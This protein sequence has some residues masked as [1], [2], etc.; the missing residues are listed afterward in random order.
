MKSGFSIP[1]TLPAP[2]HFG[3]QLRHF[4]KRPGEG[5]TRL[6]L[7]L[8]LS[9]TIKVVICRHSLAIFPFFLFYQDYYHIHYIRPC[10]SCNNMATDLLKKFKR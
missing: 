6:L 3:T 2:T 10:V 4:K 7:L 1:G 5:K 8:L 9:L